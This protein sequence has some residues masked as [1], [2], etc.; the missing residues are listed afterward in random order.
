MV[1]DDKAATGYIYEGMDLA[2]QA[3]RRR[4]GDNEAK[5][6]LLWDIID[7]RWDRQFIPPC[8]L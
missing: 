8:M 7:E 3:I 2:K 1:D 5:Y 4:Y 6:R